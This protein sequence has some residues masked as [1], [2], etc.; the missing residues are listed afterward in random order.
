[1]IVMAQ[2]STLV[3]LAPVL[4]C[5]VRLP[6]QVAVMTPVGILQQLQTPVMVL[7]ARQI[8]AT[9]N[10]ITM[11]FAHGAMLIVILLIPVRVQLLAI[12]AN[13]FGALILM[14]I[15]PA[16]VRR[17]RGCSLTRPVAHSHVKVV[18]TH[19]PMVTVTIL[20]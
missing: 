16:A 17:V 11:E 12:A 19:V 7:P 13:V 8:V 15:A 10:T 3:V 1:M 5:L 14:E 18:A 9:V 2:R 20:L 4:H 6:Q